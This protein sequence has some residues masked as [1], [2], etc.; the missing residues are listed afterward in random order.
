MSVEKLEARLIVVEQK[1]VE[2]EKSAAVSTTEF[3]VVKGDLQDIKDSLN[4]VIKLII[5]SLTLAILAF[6]YGGGLMLN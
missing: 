4:W 6:I 3:N 1:V 2:I 5:G